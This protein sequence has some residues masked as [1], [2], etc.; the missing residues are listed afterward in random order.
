MYSF[1]LLQEA[2]LHKA[3]IY[4]RGSEI[5]EIDNKRLAHYAYLVGCPNC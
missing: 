1:L 3:E 4:S 2:D 5:H